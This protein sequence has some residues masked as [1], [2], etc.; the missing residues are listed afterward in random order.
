MRRG[1]DLFFYRRY[2]DL[3]ATETTSGDAA[4]VATQAMVNAREHSK[5]YI[6]DIDLDYFSTWNPFRRGIIAADARS[7]CWLLAAVLTDL[8]R[9][10]IWKR[11]LEM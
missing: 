5:S 10:Q 2:W 4:T 8:G 9:E 3:F 6:L 1:P 7:S 11:F